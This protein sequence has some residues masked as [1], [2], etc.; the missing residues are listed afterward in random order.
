M[1][2]KFIKF[3]NK[4]VGKSRQAM[5]DFL[6]GHFRYDT[7]NC[8][9]NSTSY[10]NKVKIHS[11]ALPKDV[12]QVSWDMIQMDEWNYRMSDLMEDFAAE[13]GHLWQMGSNGRSG[14]YIVLYQGYKEKDTF[15]KS[16]CPRCGIKTGYD[17][18]NECQ[19]CHKAKLVP[20]D[21]FKIGCYPGKDVDQGEDFAEWD[22]GSLR[23]RVKLIQ[24]F[25]EACDSIVNEF[26]YYCRQYKIEDREV[27]IPKTI[28]VLVEKS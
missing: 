11:L 4:K 9:N 2:S 24:E 27:L 12:E 28:Q 20:Y 6:K 14:G 25:D 26:I 10:A 7:M 1:A 3:F 23:A 19:K 16:R 17:A 8:N 5:I 13:H 22:I 15:S 18:G 21:G